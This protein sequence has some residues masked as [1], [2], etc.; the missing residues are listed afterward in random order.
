MQR[1]ANF[2]QISFP[3]WRIL[4][5][6]CTIFLVFTIFFLPLL[7]SA[8]ISSA[9]AAPLPVSHP[10][11]ISQKNQQ[12]HRQTTKSGE[13]SLQISDFSSPWLAPGADLIF[14]VEISNGTDQEVPLKEIAVGAQR[15]PANSQYLLYYWMN[16]VIT[17]KPLFSF[18]TDVKIPA[19]E[20]KRIKVQVPRAHIPWSTARFG[21][22][23]RGVEACAVSANPKVPANTTRNNL[24]DRSVTVAAADEQLAPMPVSVV[25]PLSLN[26]AEILAQPSITDI[27]LEKNF[28][29]HCNNSRYCAKD[30]KDNQYF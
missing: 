7:S 30:S 16:N 15:T 18:P 26:S 8:E 11:N 14:T 12:P 17:A 20:I 19:G 2:S 25:F 5:V 1:K 21:W 22:G 4:A 27:L 9:Q 24:C 29:K 3:L 28:Q 23:P 6:L 13:F 10:E